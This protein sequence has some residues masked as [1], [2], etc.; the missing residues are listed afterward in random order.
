MLAFSKNKSLT[1][2][3]RSFNFLIMVPF[4]QCCIRFHRLPFKPNMSCRQEGSLRV[5]AL[6]RRVRIEPPNPYSKRGA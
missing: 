2:I 4:L 5:L 3:N 1:Q 6:L